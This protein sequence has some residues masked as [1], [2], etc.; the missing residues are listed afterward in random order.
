MLYLFNILN[1]TPVPTHARQSVCHWRQRLHQGATGKAI[2]RNTSESQ[3]NR[4]ETVK[5]DKR[6]TKIN[7]M[8]WCISESIFATKWGKEDP[9]V[10]S[11]TQKPLQAERLKDAAVTCL[12]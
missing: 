5:K 12:L 3:M 1:I 2:N 7:T 6:S 11:V 9:D 4:M 10:L 8:Y